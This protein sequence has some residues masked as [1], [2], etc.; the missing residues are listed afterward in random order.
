MNSEEKVEN[1]LAEQL[2][3]RISLGELSQYILYFEENQPDSFQLKIA[4]KAFQIRKFNLIKET[5]E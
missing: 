3:R 2:S 1:Q 5:E 4:K